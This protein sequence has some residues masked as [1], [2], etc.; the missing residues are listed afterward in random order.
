MSSS[1]SPNFVLAR[2][3]RK[4]LR[5]RSSRQTSVSSLILLSLAPPDGTSSRWS[6]GVDSVDLKTRQRFRFGGLSDAFS[7]LI[8]S[9]TSL[10]SA[11]LRD[12]SS[13]RPRSS[14]SAHRQ[15]S[16][17]CVE[18]PSALAM[19]M[20]S[21]YSHHCRAIV[22][23]LFIHLSSSTRT[24]PCALAAAGLWQVTPVLFPRKGRMGFALSD[25]MGKPMN[26]GL[27]FRSSAIFVSTW[28]TFNSSSRTWRSN[29][30]C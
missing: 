18:S 20:R 4:V 3:L 17:A 2:S 7:F 16:S 28:R 13:W 1:L 19:S 21:E 14:A 30:S 22:A 11:I 5:F 15:T 24:N 9:V 10:A 25:V 6:F 23:C 8:S 12:S 27:A 29:S 26:A